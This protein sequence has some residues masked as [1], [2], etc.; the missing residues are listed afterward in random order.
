MGGPLGEG[1][2]STRRETAPSEGWIHRSTVLGVCAVQT[3]SVMGTSSL[4]NFGWGMGEGNGTC[5]HLCSPESSVLLGPNNSPSQHPLTL[6][7]LPAELLTF[8][9]PDVKSWWLS[10]LMQSHPST[11]A[12]QTSGALPC[13]AGCLSTVPAPSHQ[14][15]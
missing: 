5:Q 15:V 3:S 14:S 10:E 6:P 9:I 13:P 12:S 7:A 2:C 1:P 8:N 11:S 4:W